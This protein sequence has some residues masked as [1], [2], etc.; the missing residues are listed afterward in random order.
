M[1]ILYIIHIH[2]IISP[3]KC[4]WFTFFKLC[5]ISQKPLPIRRPRRSHSAAAGLET[6]SVGPQ[7]RARRAIRKIRCVPMVINHITRISP[8]IKTSKYHGQ[9]LAV[10]KKMSSFV[11]FGDLLILLYIYI[12]TYIAKKTKGLSY[13]SKVGDD[14]SVSTLGVPWGGRAHSRTLDSEVRPC[15]CFKTIEPTRRISGF[16]EG[17]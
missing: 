15:A 3:L 8:C 4:H 10:H 9:S 12:Y 7:W 17:N 13:L 6:S 2:T 16:A 5:Y 14:T 11:G 1:Y